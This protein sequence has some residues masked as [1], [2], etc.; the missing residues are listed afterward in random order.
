MIARAAFAIVSIVYKM[1]NEKS[2]ETCRKNKYNGKE[3]SLFVFFEKLENKDFMHN[4]KT[5]CCQFI[6]NFRKLVKH[7]IKHA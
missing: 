2:V 6:L 3:R 4:K 7:T 1:K 5:F